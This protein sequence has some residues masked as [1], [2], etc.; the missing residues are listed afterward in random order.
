VE[1]GGAGLGLPSPLGQSKLMVGESV[2]RKAETDVRFESVTMRANSSKR[3]RFDERN[4]T[5]GKWIFRRSSVGQV[6]G[7]AH[8]SRDTSEPRA[9][10]R[11]RSWVIAAFVDS[12]LGSCSALRCCSH[13]E[14]Q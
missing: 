6:G 1:W 9:L 14:A 13:S 5:D 7:A 2:A 10:R 8:G 3:R 11:I 12:P 4:S